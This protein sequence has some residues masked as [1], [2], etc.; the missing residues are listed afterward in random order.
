MNI[1][2]NHGIS[3]ILAQYTLKKIPY[4]EVL[5]SHKIGL[6]IEMFE[7]YPGGQNKYNYVYTV[8]PR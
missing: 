5:G 3:G 6:R 8:E 2:I 1:H 4:M 7:S